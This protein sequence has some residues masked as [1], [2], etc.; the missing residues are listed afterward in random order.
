MNFATDKNSAAPLIETERL[1][2]RSHQLDDFDDCVAMWADPEIARFTIG[3]PSLPARTWARLLAYCGH[4]VMLGFGY[5]AVEEKA[6]GRFIGEFGFADFKRDEY[7]E[8][9]SM[10]EL[11]WVLAAHV[12]GR[13]YATEGL[14]A[15]SDWGDVNFGRRPTVCVIQRDNLRSFN[16]AKR[17]GYSAMDRLPEIDNSPIILVRSPPETLKI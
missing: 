15:I 7:P 17:L 1:L 4:W 3:S 9:H 2:L 10:P 14:R 8:I 11:G 16:V 13:G 12:H 6:S 5:W